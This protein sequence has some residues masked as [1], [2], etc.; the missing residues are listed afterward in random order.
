L[1]VIEKLLRERV[2]MQNCIFGL[3]PLGNNNT[4]SSALGWG[5]K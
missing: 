4:L 3:L 5:G 1:K 2:N